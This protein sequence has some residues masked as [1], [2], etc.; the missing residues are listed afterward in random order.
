MSD[1][2][3]K[4]GEC[5][6]CGQQVKFRVVKDSRGKGKDTWV[7]VGERH[8]APCGKVCVRSRDTTMREVLEGKVHHPRECECQKVGKGYQ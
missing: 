1:E 5:P 8:F 6:S 2:V 3:I 4:H 7:L